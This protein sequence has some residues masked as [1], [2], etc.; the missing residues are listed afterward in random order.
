MTDINNAAT[1]TT[2]GVLALD[3][4]GDAIFSEWYPNH[5]PGDPVPAMPPLHV[6]QEARGLAL[7]HRIVAAR[8]AGRRE[9]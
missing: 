3:A 5:R 9:A 7:R 8:R 6:M 1:I 4:I 2:A